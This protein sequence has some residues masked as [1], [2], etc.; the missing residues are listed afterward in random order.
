MQK[1]ESWA[2]PSPCV[3]IFLE[4]LCDEAHA[5]MPEESRG[6]ASFV[7]VAEQPHQQTSTSE[8][9]HLAIHKEI[10]Q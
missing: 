4:M 7:Q 1:R 5:L 9:E 2:T 10:R 6:L 3:R 8:L